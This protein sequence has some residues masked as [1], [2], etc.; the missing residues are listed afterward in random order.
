M[1]GRAA[2]GN[3]AIFRLIVTR[4][5]NQPVPELDTA[6]R[7]SMMKRYLAASLEYLGEFHGCRM[8][9]SR[10]GWFSK[11]LPHSSRF[12]E[13][14]KRIATEAEATAA[15]NRYEELLMSQQYI[16]GGPNPS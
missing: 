9:R 3:P 15:I 8:M 1:V 7:L 2:I 16:R 4:L 13:S 11:G 14:I 12:R 6:Q 10:L 5:R